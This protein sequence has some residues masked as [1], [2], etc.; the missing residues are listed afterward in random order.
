M[1]RGLWVQAELVAMATDLA[2]IVGGALALYLLFGIPLPV[3]GLITCV[4]AF[5][6]LALQRRG[7][8]AR[9]RR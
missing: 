9:S 4:V 5:V 2:E 7:V 6:L 1:S 3:G 8:P